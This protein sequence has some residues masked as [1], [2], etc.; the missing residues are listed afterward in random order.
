MKFW[1]LVF[2]L[3]HAADAIELEDDPLTNSIRELFQ[4]ESAPASPTSHKL[5]DPFDPPADSADP[6]VELEKEVKIKA[7]S[8]PQAKAVELKD[9]FAELAA[10]HPSPAVS[11]DPAEAAP[12]VPRAVELKDPFAELAATHPSPA[13]SKDPAEAV[14][15]VPRA[16]ELKDPFAELAATHPSPAVSKDPAEAV[17]KV[18][19][20]VELKDPFAE[21]AATHPSPAVSKDPAEAVPKVPRAVELKDPFAELAAT[22]PSP[23][24]SK[25]P[26]EAVPKVPRAVELKDPF[27]E[28]AATHPSPAVSKDPA[29]A[30]PKVPRAVELKDPFAELAATHPSPAVSKDPAEAVPKASRAAE[31]ATIHPSPAGLA[32]ESNG[33]LAEFAS[34]KVAGKI[35]AAQQ[36]HLSLAKSSAVLPQPTASLRST[37]KRNTSVVA[38]KSASNIKPSPSSNRSQ[39]LDVK[40]PKAKAA[41]DEKVVS[42][43]APHRAPSSLAAFWAPQAPQTEAMALVQAR[44]SHGIDFTKVQEEKEDPDISISDMATVPIKKGFVN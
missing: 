24:V 18:P 38:V 22:H 28:L 32:K 43:S 15:K 10:T 36:L 21:L 13:V 27:A 2:V 42:H 7:P 6:F 17:P 33:S 31:L 14:P 37:L 4:E 12:K 1:W 39:T 25:D 26:A 19:R 41:K 5:L 34:G 29:E 9:P 35:E 30:V 16:V 3:V 11:K 23:A 8:H 20:A 40:L 44:A